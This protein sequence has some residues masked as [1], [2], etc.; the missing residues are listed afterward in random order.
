VEV[1][2][3]NKG[4]ITAL[5][6]FGVVFS[7]DHY[8]VE[9]LPNGAVRVTCWNDDPDDQDSSLFYARVVDFW[10]LQADPTMGGAIN[11]KF[12]QTIY[13]GPGLSLPVQQY[14]TVVPWSQF[15]PP[16]P[17]I[18][19]H[20]IWLP[21]QLYEEHNQAQT[22]HGWREW[23]AGVPAEDIVNGRV[24]PQRPEGRY[25]KPDGTR[26]YYASDTDL[27]NDIHA[28][29]EE[30]AYLTTTGT[31]QQVV[32]DKLDDNGEELFTF[33]TPSGEP[34]S[35]AWPTGNYRAQLDCVSFHADGEFGVLDLG[36]SGHFARVNAAISSDLETKQQQESAFI[37]TGLK[38]ATT[39]SV[40]WS[41]GAATDRFEVLV[42]GRRTTGHA[43]IYLTLE[44]NEADDYADGP[45]AELVEE[46]S[47]TF[48][49]C[50]F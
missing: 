28:A 15:S 29:D 2:D 8:A 50:N 14:T 40:S 18:A 11:T 6:L 46:K 44:L 22:T 41:A 1:P 34:A 38:L 42:S 26:T 5:N 10:P 31:S 4:W 3:G 7:G 17:S 13:A 21:D 16:N 45:W 27:A 33:V 23:T 30:K 49:G 32:S 35:A 25:I 12:Q 20:G 43:S 47:A 36:A 9:D 24:K 48:F 39:G 19:R 37:L